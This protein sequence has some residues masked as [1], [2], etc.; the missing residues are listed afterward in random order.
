RELIAQG[1]RYFTEWRSCFYQAM[2]FFLEKDK[3]YCKKELESRHYYIEYNSYFSK[4]KLLLI[5]T[6]LNK[7]YGIIKGTVHYN[8]IAENIVFNSF[9]AA[10]ADMS[11]FC[12][13]ETSSIEY[14]LYGFVE[15]EVQNAQRA[16]SLQIMRIDFPLGPSSEKDDDQNK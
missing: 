13:D 2:K 8:D 10:Y 3:R 5:E 7:M 9:N 1:Q 6:Y 12:E 4:A 15:K 16:E 14:W 11:N